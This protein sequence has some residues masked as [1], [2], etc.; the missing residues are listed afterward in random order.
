MREMK[1]SGI[2]GLGTIPK[3]WK[4]K[5]AKYACDSL[6]KGNG[7]TKEEVKE[8]GN[9]CCVRYGEIYSKYNGSFIKCISSTDI[10][11]IPSPKYISKGDILFAGTGELVE[12]IGKNI[13]YMGEEKCLA[14]GDIVVMK[15]SLNPIFL[16]YALNCSYS[17]SQKS[18]GKAKLKV[19]HI[20]AR[21]IG[22]ILIALPGINEQE[23]IANFLD[24]KCSEIDALYSD[25]SGQISTLEEYKKSVITETVTKGVRADRTM[26]DSGVE[27]ND[28]IP[29]EWNEAKLKYLVYLRARLGWR[30]LKADEYV[31]NGFIFLS[32]F[33]IINNKLDFSEVNYINQFRYDESPEIKLK[34]GDVLIVKDGAGIGKCAYVDY[35]PRESTPNGS[36]AVI[37]PNDKLYGKYLYYYFLSSM[38]QERILQLKDGMGVPHLFQGDMREILIPVPNVEEQQEIANYLDQQCSE[39]DALIEEKKEQLATLEEYKKSL[40]Y[41]YVTG[42]KEVV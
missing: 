8:S 31:D 35:M 6:S 32:A 16:N 40:I 28:F 18:K 37:T 36:L 25:I 2:D 20:S 3:H 23:K 1:D 38:F 30:G 13:V 41:E 27:Y 17:Q 4:I 10:E 39:V 24:Q 9:I 33:N 22:N 14:G 21:D 15:H 19:V 34:L 5:R 12:E 7:I 26:K 11:L 29:R 42:K